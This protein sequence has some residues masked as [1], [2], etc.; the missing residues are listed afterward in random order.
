MGARVMYHN[1]NGVVYFVV[2]VV[3]LWQK[4]DCHCQWLGWLTLINTIA[5][6]RLDC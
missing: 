1:V 4:L 6:G 3:V 2:R 5:T